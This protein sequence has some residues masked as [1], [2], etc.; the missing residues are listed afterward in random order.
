MTTTAL[1]FSFFNYAQSFFLDPS[2]VKNAPE[3]AIT[4]IALYFRGKPKETNNKSGI[5]S[6]G[7]EIQIIP[8]INGIPALTAQGTVRPTEATEHGA[9]FA[10]GPN[11]IS[12][13]EWGGIQASFDAS[14]P[15]NFVFNNPV[16]VK[17][18]AEYSILIKFDGNEDFILWS[19][20]K[21]DKLVGTNNLSPGS[22]GNL[23]G[24]LF[25]FISPTTLTGNTGTV[26]NTKTQATIN[27]PNAATAQQQNQEN[28][29]FQANWKPLPNEDLKFEVFCARYK[30]GNNVIATN[31]TIINDPTIPGAPPP[32]NP[33]TATQDGTDTVLSVVA[34]SDRSEFIIFERKFSSI[35]SLR[36]GE[37]VYQNTVF[38]PGNRIVNGV[39]TPLTVSIGPQSTTI[40][41]NG[42]YILANGSTFN[43]SGGFN[44][45]FN[46]NPADEEFIAIVSGNT[47][48][49]RRI[50]S[51]TSNTTVTVSGNPITITNNAAYFMKA[52]VGFIT[53]VGATYAFGKMEDMLTLYDSNANADVRFVNNTIETVTVSTAG[54]GY[55]NNMYLRINGFEDVANSVKGGYS[56]FANIVTNSSGNVTSIF[57][58]NAGCGF[59]NTAWLT[60]SNI[61]TLNSS[62]QPV[63]T[64]VANGATYTFGVGATLKSEFNNG[65][66]GNVSIV[67]LESMR[68]KPEITVNNPLGTTYAIRHRTLFT[69]NND[70][71]TTSGKAYYINPSPAN[72]D[73]YVKIFKSAQIS[74]LN[75]SPVIPSR[76][77]QFVIRYEANGA[78]ANTTVIGDR[79]SN[80]AI[81]IF[82]VSSNNDYT[83][84]FFDPGVI[85]SFYSK[86][87]INNDYTDEHTNYGNAHAKHITTKV[88]FSKDRLAEDLLVYLT[89]YRPTD[90]DIKV[91]ARIHNSS[92]PEAFEDKDWTLL[93]QIDGN[94]VF[95]SKTNQSDYNEYTYNFP[96]SPNTQSTLTGSVSVKQGNDVITGTCTAFTSAL[97]SNDLIKIYPPLFPENYIVAVV[98]NIVNNTSL[99][100]KRTFGELSA[101]LTGTV[102]VNT[103][104]PNVTGT[105]TSFN[106]DF[107][108]GDYVAVWNTGSV[109]EVR[110]I[111]VVS[112]STS[113]N[114][115][116]NF[117]FANTTSFY[118][119]VRANTFSNSVTGA[120]LRMDKLAFKNQAFNNKI[121]SNVVRYHSTS[122]I[123]YDG[124]DTFQIKIVLLSENA[125]VVPKVDDVRAIGVSS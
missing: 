92:D 111:N 78:P 48:N 4:K 29:W 120:G 47:V 53:S 62:G 35:N 37:A 64:S 90:T 121:N 14:I 32:L 91:Y 7:V 105:S 124:Y 52:P 80:A 103:T 69:V 119:S 104:S 38:Y 59:N 51:V 17:T 5:A 68:T 114:V 107:S 30:V 67:N 113:M 22:S 25:K 87:I 99:S 66:F 19:N 85:H 100:I 110:K 8:C 96:Q 108:N 31:N 58:S 50:T 28:T 27:T 122:M 56:A 10:S 40:T 45:I 82:D 57:V 117:S 44:N 109:Y 20:I 16:F 112:N 1:P 76:S 73:K 89:A 94:N 36:Y 63:L 74:D 84:P 72:S 21:G 98:N 86:Y 88:N 15:T 79:H 123:E 71:R 81:F 6:P 60:G 55:S 102:S 3:V 115:D 18:N 125:Y 9:R 93:E 42:N 49:V 12:R 23:I 116:A 97:S 46:N 39:Q 106:T 13:V 118:A 33:I 2:G 75:N 70:L 101:N 65:V 34:P 95:S 83:I 24:N 11:E 54:V 61:V 77:N 26:N 43:A 41:A